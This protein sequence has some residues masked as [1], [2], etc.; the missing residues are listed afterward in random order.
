MITALPDDFS[1]A[2]SLIEAAAD[3]QALDGRLVAAYVTTSDGNPIAGAR[4]R[5]RTAITGAPPETL[6]LRFGG[7]PPEIQLAE[8]LAGQH[9]PVATATLS[10]STST[11]REAQLQTIDGTDLEATS[12]LACAG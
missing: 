4:G 11:F 7:Q 2:R 3:L 10:L 12:A 9:L 1:G 5:V 8:Y 6:T